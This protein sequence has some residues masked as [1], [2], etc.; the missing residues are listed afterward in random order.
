MSEDTEIYTCLGTDEQL[1]SLVDDIIKQY[2]ESI[3]K[4]KIIDL[5]DSQIEQLNHHL[6]YQ[7][8]E[9]VIILGRDS[10]ILRIRKDDAGYDPIFYMRLRIGEWYEMK[11]NE[12]LFQHYRD[13]Y[14]KLW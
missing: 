5:A 2:G 4:Q 7:F 10:T 12:I 11:F 1:K 6:L 8:N 13:I 3:T 14:E 9:L